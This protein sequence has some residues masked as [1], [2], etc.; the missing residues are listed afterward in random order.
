MCQM[1]I[2]PCTVHEIVLRM[3]IIINCMKPIIGSLKTFL[4]MYYNYD[5]SPL[6]PASVKRGLF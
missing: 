3:T 5:S 4:V 6:V 1:S 2:Q